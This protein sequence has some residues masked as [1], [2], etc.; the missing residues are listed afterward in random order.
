[1]PSPRKRA[2]NR[3]NAQRSTGPRTPEGK[4]QSRL[5][6]LKHG[7]A[8]PATALPELASDL[9]QLAQTLAGEAADDPIVREAA[10]R[11]AEAALDVLRARRAKG[12][13]LARLGHDPACPPASSAREPM[14]TQGPHRRPARAART[15]TIRT[16]TEEPWLDAF[17]PTQATRDDH[18]R[19]AHQHAPDW[20]QLHKLDRYERRA[21][22]RRNR[23]IKA[24]DAARGA[25]QTATRRSN[26]IWQNDPSDVYPLS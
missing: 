22:S 12:A 4:A 25:H 11:V 6:G 26:S 7:L 17:L 15:Q 19:Q 24:L 13:L 5:N 23:A 9:A 10:L 16:A 21:L 3:G 1:M 14:P 18:N 8:I 20:D 2:A